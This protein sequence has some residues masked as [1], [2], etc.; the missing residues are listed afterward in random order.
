MRVVS[1]PEEGTQIFRADSGTCE[2]PGA[3]HSARAATIENQH[4]KEAEDL[5]ISVA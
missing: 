4:G 3:N 5:G 2:K 1:V